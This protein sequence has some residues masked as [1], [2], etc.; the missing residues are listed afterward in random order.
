MPSAIPGRI[1][2]FSGVKKFSRGFIKFENVEISA[3]ECVIFR[4]EREL[5]FRQDFGERG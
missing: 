2:V 5:N 3:E 1:I 4:T